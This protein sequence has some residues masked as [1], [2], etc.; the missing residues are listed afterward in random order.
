[1]LFVPSWLNAPRQNAARLLDRP[2]NHCHVRC[3]VAETVER[4]AASTVDADGYGCVG[5][6]VGATYPDEL[7]ALR[8]AMPHAPLLVPG[9]GSQGGTA[10]D[11]AAAMDE[12]GLGAVIN[13][14][15]AINFAY[16]DKQY[17]E[18]FGL[19]VG[20]SLIG[21]AWSEPTLIRLAAGFE[22]VTAAR[23]PPSFLE[24]LD[25]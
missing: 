7:K 6:V 8:A 11:V 15:R 22:H 16:R 14:S 3:R 2:R 1:M 20:I 10:S 13:S 12:N 23:R 5:A 21:P 4:L 19:P 24:R 9:Y 25:D 18:A 17:G